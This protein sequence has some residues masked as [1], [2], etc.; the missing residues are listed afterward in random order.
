M[1]FCASR[2]RLLY[3]K[4][5]A[6]T[7]WCEEEVRRAELEA[8][9]SK[10]H[11]VRWPALFLLRMATQYSIWHLI[12]TGNRDGEWHKT[13]TGRG[14]TIWSREGVDTTSIT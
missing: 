9:R 10:S 6:G 3:T 11:A 7:I 5:E 8:A 1:V 4:A 2:D 13:P 14:L 12:R